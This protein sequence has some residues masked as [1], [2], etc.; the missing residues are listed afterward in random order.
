[1]SNTRFQRPRLFL[2][3]WRS[4]VG[5]LRL[6]K[7]D[8]GVALL[9]FV[10]PGGSAA[11]DARLQ[12]TFMLED[13]KAEIAGLKSALEEYLSGARNDLE[14]I[15]D[16]ALMRSDFQRQVLDITTHVPYGTVTTYQGIAERLGRP[17]AIRA[18]GQAIGHNPVAIH[19]PCHR[20]VGSNGSLTGYAGSVAVKRQILATEGIPIVE[21]SPGPLVAKNLCYIGWH[22]LGSFCTQ[23]CVSVGKR[24]FAGD[25]LLIAS[26]ARAQ[27]L[28]YRP[29][30]ECRPDVSLPT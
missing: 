3:V 21:T 22:R 1:M 18:V 15:V 12:K 23:Q 9:E 6:G 10:K 27:E 19:I 25:S 11:L 7:T 4:S 17:D 26:R 28:G 20:V 5:D 30:Q 2:H 29:C 13:G 14:W 24:P 8:K 16:D